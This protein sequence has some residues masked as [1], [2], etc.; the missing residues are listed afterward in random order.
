MLERATWI[1][2]T[3]SLAS[4]GCAME[5]DDGA[6]YGFDP[7]DDVAASTEA[8]SR[9]RVRL[10]RHSGAPVDLGPASDR[11]CFITGINGFL[12]GSVV[13][14]RYREAA[15]D[16]YVNRG[17]WYA[18][19][20]AGADNAGNTYPVPPEVSVAC[21][22]VPYQSTRVMTW[23][24]S[25]TQATY[26]RVPR[27]ANRSC[28]LS[29]VASTAGFAPTGGYRFLQ[30]TEGDTHWSFDGSYSPPVGGLPPPNV[31]ARAVCIDFPTS[32]QWD[33]EWA[34]GTNASNTVLEHTVVRQWYP[35][36]PELGANDYQCG[37]TG[38][39]GNHHL[40]TPDPFVQNNQTTV[41]TGDVF[42]NPTDQWRLT[43]TNGRW[44]STRCVRAR[45]SVRG[46]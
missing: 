1:A 43:A 40:I 6:A 14:G 15:V 37:L 18:S 5:M 34:A 26:N 20:K 38:V 7:D 23:N 2:L 41:G 21:V 32:G 19:T 3:L 28:F 17:R 9:V 24:N 33:Y 13:N 39:G 44:L 36:G 8:L 25:G 16:V 4:A 10:G 29:Y 12:L 45:R 46:G 31:W 30:V 35:S 11:T 22:N 27:Q 42:G